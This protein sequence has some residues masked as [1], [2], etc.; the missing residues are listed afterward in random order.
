MQ[1]IIEY[2]K[3]G[4][5]EAN[6]GRGASGKFGD[7]GD[8]PGTRIQGQVRTF[9]SVALR[10][11]DGPRKAFDYG[12]PLTDVNGTCRGCLSCGQIPELSTIM[13]LPVYRVIYRCDAVG[14]HLAAF[15]DRDILS[16]RKTFVC[17]MKSDLVWRVL[18]CTV[19]ECP[20][21]ALAVYEM[22]EPVFLELGAAARDPDMLRDARARAP[23][24]SDRCHRAGRR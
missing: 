6:Y 12:W 19:V 3:I 8:V 1:L 22:A 21:A 17:K 24:R 18:G 16:R 7:V 20:A 2:A 4:R 10:S 15:V 14:V 5:T 13:I 23:G 9:G 11:N